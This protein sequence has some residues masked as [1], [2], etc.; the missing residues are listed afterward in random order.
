MDLGWPV[1]GAKKVLD[2]IEGS[3]IYFFF[4]SLARACLLN[5]EFHKKGLYEKGPF[6]F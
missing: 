2:L 1:V 5:W 4:N 3:L 6:M